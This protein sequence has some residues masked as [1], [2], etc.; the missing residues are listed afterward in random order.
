MT[1]TLRAIETR[2]HGY[3]F[4]SRLE[5][6][7]AVFFDALGV[8]W[9]YEREGFDLGAVGWY[10]PDFWLPQ[11]DC[12]VEIRP[13]E[14]SPHEPCCEELAKRSGQHVLYVRGNPYPDE[15]AI[16]LYAPDDSM[17]TMSPGYVFALGRRDPRT[18]CVYNEDAG[19]ARW[20]GPPGD[21]G[22]R[23][24]LSD[25]AKLIA[26]YNAARGARFEHGECGA[27]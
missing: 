24:P 19:A 4:R 8:P 21:D 13:S 23:Y 15:Y 27:P 11:Q 3:R 16:E 18:V 26:A 22:E 17:R 9:E 25:C 2:Y 20:L 5:A 12:W 14:A 10:L 6:R 7:W 1:I